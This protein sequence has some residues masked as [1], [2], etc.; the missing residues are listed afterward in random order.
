M[1]TIRHSIL[2]NSLKTHARLSNSTSPVAPR[3]NE[4]RRPPILHYLPPCWRR[5]DDTW[6]TLRRRTVKGL[7]SYVCPTRESTSNAVLLRICTLYH[8]N[9]E[10]CVSFGHMWGNS[11][12]KLRLTRQVRWTHTEDLTSSLA[13]I[14]FNFWVKKENLFKTAVF[15][16]V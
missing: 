5:R 14:A 9:G 7:I 4:R 11:G 3:K 15:L 8:H 10:S 2:N 12:I 1:T 16:I 6:D 13:T